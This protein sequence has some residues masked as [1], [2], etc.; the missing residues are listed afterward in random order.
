MGGRPGKCVRVKVRVAICSSSAL[1]DFRNSYF[2]VPKKPF[3]SPFNT[4]L[5]LI[6]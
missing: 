4:L 3:L 2:V 1:L 5:S 6:S